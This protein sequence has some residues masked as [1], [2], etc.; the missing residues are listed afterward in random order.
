MDP[1]DRR[2]AA[3][4]AS[5][6]DTLFWLEQVAA[7]IPYD[8]R[9]VVAIERLQPQPAQLLGWETGP[10]HAATRL[11]NDGEAVEITF[12]GSVNV[13]FVDREGETC[14]V[15]RPFSVRREF[16]PVEPVPPHG[17]VRAL[18][19][20]TP[21][22]GALV[23]ANRPAGFR[24]HLH[25]HAWITVTEPVLRH[26][27]PGQ[28]VTFGRVHA[29]VEP[30][31]QKS[32]DTPHASPDAP[33]DAYSKTKPAGGEAGQAEPEGAEPRKADGDASE[34]PRALEEQNSSEQAADP[35]QPA[36]AKEA[37]R[38][39]PAVAPEPPAAQGP[40]SRSS[41]QTGGPAE[42]EQP[43]TAGEAEGAPKETTT[44]D[45]SSLPG[46]ESSALPTE[47]PIVPSQPTELTAPRSRRPAGAPAL[48]WRLPQ[49]DPVGKTAAPWRRTSRPGSRE[50][51]R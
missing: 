50:G 9:H 10:V 24:G 36:D 11:I 33:A 45:D 40:L 21:G 39:D 15:R 47:K 4:E 30:A 41:Q 2:S 13:T 38:P 25:L 12:F 51:S 6:P 35:D 46:H 18:A 22:E 3:V 5:P 32:P 37:A 44:D 31:S 49:E 26:G 43:D 14:R 27:I 20:G 29:D 19:T 48:V 16:L 1:R 17:Q 23:P 7:H 34:E 42:R 28:P 8:V